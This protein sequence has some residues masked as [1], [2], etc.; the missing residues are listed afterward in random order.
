VKGGTAVS[1]IP[2]DYTGWNPALTQSGNSQALFVMFE[3]L[4]K[5]MPNGDLA[6]QLAEALPTISSDGLTYTFKLRQNV[7]WS[8]GTPLTVDDVVF[9][10]QLAFDP[11]YEAQRARVYQA[12]DLASKIESITAPDESTVVIRTKQPFASFLAIHGIRY[13]VPKSV[14]GNV[15]VEELHTHPF[16][17]NPS[18]VTGPFKFQEFKRA[19]QLTLVRNDLYWQGPPYLDRWI[20]RFYAD[21]AA[22]AIGL[23]TKEIDYLR[24]AQF[25]AY[26][27]IK[28]LSHINTKVIPDSGNPGIWFNLDP[29]R[30]TSKI[31]QSKAVRQAM[32][33]AVDRASIVKAT[34]FS[35]GAVPPD[36]GYVYPSNWAY[37]NSSEHMWTFDKAKAEAM[38]DAQGWT[39][40][41]DGIRA[42]DGMPLS[43]E[44]HTSADNKAYSDTAVILQ[45]QWTAI[46]ANVTVR[47]ERI[48]E[49]QQTE[50]ARTYDVTFTGAGSPVDPDFLSL[51]LHSRNAVPG[52]TNIA[53]YSNPD[54]D[55]LLDS[56]ATEIDRDK[57]KPIYADL[58]K[59]LNDEVPFYSTQYWTQLLIASKRMH[60][61][62]EPAGVYNYTQPTWMKDV[63]VD[64]GK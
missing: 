28:A 49:W 40:G 52:G 61:A 37:D 25:N 57:R 31:F 24:S 15:P 53:A 12:S 5:T 50:R 35:Y 23:E 3:G 8:D 54:V 10:Y 39:R 9:S 7:K 11:K 58:Q 29:A 42:K 59:L 16:N 22:L 36:A 2:G 1:G 6:P 4:L 62:L 30:P 46:G 43:F 18:V 19:E 34:T 38:L 41:S 48:Q 63:W 64:D 14:L 44:M 20:E 51:M 17:Q 26:D 60:N 32:L 47:A 27:Q 55:R 45:Q 13:I 56:G 21:Q 33:Y